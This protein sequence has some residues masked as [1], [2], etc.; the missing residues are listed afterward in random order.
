MVQANYRLSQHFGR[1]YLMSRTSH[2]CLLITLIRR[3]CRVRRSA[4][5]ACGDNALRPENI[6]FEVL[7][8]NGYEFVVCAAALGKPAVTMREDQGGDDPA[9]DQRALA[10]LSGKSADVRTANGLH[11][12]ANGRAT[13]RSRRACPRRHAFLGVWHS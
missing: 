12:S 6:G 9:A 3:L 4:G 11:V 1:K 13:G 8:A 7:F 10:A 5:Q 2:Q